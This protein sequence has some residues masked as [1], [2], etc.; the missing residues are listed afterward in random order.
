MKVKGKKHSK[1]RRNNKLEK[2]KG[3][4]RETIRHENKNVGVEQVEEE[5]KLLEEKG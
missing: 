5:G 4:S 2:R 1:E 3:G